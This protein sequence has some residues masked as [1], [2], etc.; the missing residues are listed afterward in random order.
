METNKNAPHTPGAI[1]AALLKRYP[2]L[3]TCHREIEEAYTVLIRCFQGGGLLLVAG[4]GGSAADS[5]HISGELLKSFRLRRGIDSDTKRILKRLFGDEGERV[6]VHLEGALPVLPLV[7]FNSVLTAYSNDVDPNFAFAQVLYGC[8]RPGD[9]FLAITTSG[10][11]E[12]IYQALMV[13]RAKGIATICLTGREKGR[14][15]RIADVAIHVP[16]DETYLIQEMHLPVYHAMCAMLEA[17][18]FGQ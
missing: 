6:A 14:C 15:S 10:N 18:F 7:A 16:E 13:A 2:E 9:T 11:S 17:Y 3:K 5:E 8:G 1:M 12:N 4:N